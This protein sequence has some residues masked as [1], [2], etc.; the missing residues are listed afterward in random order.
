MSGRGRT[1]GTQGAGGSGGTQAPGG[2]LTS[3]QRT[4]ARRVWC[5]DRECAYRFLLPVKLIFENQDKYESHPV[6]V[7]L[8]SRVQLPNVTT[9][10]SHV[11]SDHHPWLIAPRGYR[12][13]RDERRYEWVANEGKTAQ[14][15][16]RGE[17]MTAQI[18]FFV[19]QADKGLVD[20]EVL[21]ELER[22]DT[23]TFRKQE[24]NKFDEQATKNLG[25][26]RVDDEPVTEKPS[27]DSGSDEFNALITAS[28]D[29]LINQV[30]QDREERKTMGNNFQAMFN[31][32]Q[33]EMK[34]IRQS[35]ANLE[36]EKKE[37]EKEKKRR[38]HRES[39]RETRESQHQ[40]PGEFTKQRDRAPAGRVEFSLESP[41]LQNATFRELRG[42]SRQEQ[43]QNVVT[44]TP[45]RSSMH[46]SSSRLT[47]SMLMGERGLIELLRD[48][49][50]TIQT[51]NGANLS[52]RELAS[53]LTKWDSLFE[54]TEGAEQ[55]ERVLRALL[56]K[57]EGAPWEVVNKC[58]QAGETWK[59]IRKTLDKDFNTLGGEKGT[60]YLWQSLKQGE[61]SMPDHIAQVREIFRT[62]GWDL[63][64]RDSNKCLKFI[65]SLSDT[66]I[67]D[68]LQQK[69]D[70]MNL[71]ELLEHARMLWLN[72]RTRKMGVSGDGAHIMVATEERVK[73]QGE[74]DPCPVH[75]TTK[76]SWSECRHK[77]A[78]SCPYC[79]EGV[80]QGT[81]NKHIITCK[82]LRCYECGKL[83]H[84][85][86]EC[87][88]LQKKG[89]KRRHESGSRNR[90]QSSRGP[91][92]H[93]ERKPRSKERRR[94][95]SRDHRRRN[96]SD[97]R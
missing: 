24:A 34:E 72:N 57:V 31:S 49:T 16:Y 97:K 48:T 67:Q 33:A 4:F 76:H 64:T 96:E 54:A 2:I 14:D 93:E 95:P 23:W 75:S 65:W 78:K 13:S 60:I 50:K 8:S 44:S 19:E 3:T 18:V 9:S 15:Q 68:K 17:Q 61:E 88:K 26:E 66:G 84:M 43:F 79:Q 32:L 59:R 82:G 5:P 47:N 53:W 71:D 56:L 38:K 80:Q 40:E 20:A 81:L 87:G 74:T 91:R 52:R 46:D 90:R 55:E 63:K 94:H 27:V 6:A 92:R 11:R 28:I 35:N 7:E 70:K 25:D 73:N 51:F 42:R 41:S 10:S 69:L 45:F 30:K 62:L 89:S 58:K 86:S 21:K 77:D 83:G 29:K 37:W 22:S 1:G 12:W 36:R 85:R 39:R